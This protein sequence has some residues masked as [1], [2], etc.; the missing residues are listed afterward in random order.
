[1]K[2]IPAVAVAFALSTSLFSQTVI[3]NRTC[4]KKKNP[5]GID[6]PAPRLSWQLTAKTRN[7]LQAEYQI[8]VKNEESGLVW[9][10][11]K[12]MSSQS[13]LVPYS[14]K[15]LGMGKRYNWQ[16]RVWG[17]SR[18]TVFMLFLVVSVL[19]MLLI[20]YYSRKLILRG[21]IR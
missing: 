17:L 8:R 6:M 20:V 9:L 18:Y 21:Y 3:N 12:V 11:D 19:Q 5:L 4:E 14:G 7:V 2:S 13:V 15:P 16:V 10:T 1:M